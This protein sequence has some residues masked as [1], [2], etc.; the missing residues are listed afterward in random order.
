MNPSSSTVNGVPSVMSMISPRD[1][2]LGEGDSRGRQARA[3]MSVLSGGGYLATLQSKQAA[4]RQRVIFGIKLDSAVV[5][6]K[7]RC[8][9]QG[10]CGTGERIEHEIAGRGER[11]DQRRQGAE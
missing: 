5:A 6:T 1:G 7:A 4:P 9:D 11:L 10:G 8:R 3:T 2:T